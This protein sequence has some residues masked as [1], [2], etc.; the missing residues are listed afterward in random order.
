MNLS[1]VKN[2]FTAG[3]VRDLLVSIV[4]NNGQ[5]VG[6]SNVLAGKHDIP[7]R[8]EQ[9][10]RIELVVALEGGANLVKRNSVNSALFAQILE[11]AFYVQPYG[12]LIGSTAH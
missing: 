3:H 4:Y 9:P 7:C 10:F 5:M 12:I 8:T 11:C 1:E 2:V 6:R